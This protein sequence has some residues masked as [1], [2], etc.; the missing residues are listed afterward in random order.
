MCIKQSNH[1]LSPSLL[2]CIWQCIE[3]MILHRIAV[4]YTATHVEWDLLRAYWTHQML[5]AA[6]NIQ[7]R[8]TKM[9]TLRH[10]ELRV[11][12]HNAVFNIVDWQRQQVMLN[13][14]FD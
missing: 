13:I 12:S 10:N 8:L 9:Y 3:W 7:S 5:N 2:F 4:I 14:L 1:E 11:R 6:K